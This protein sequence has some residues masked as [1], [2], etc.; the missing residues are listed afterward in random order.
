MENKKIDIDVM[1]GEIVRICIDNPNLLTACDL[2][3]SKIQE[4]EIQN[5]DKEY[6]KSDINWLLN[7][8]ESTSNRYM[9]AE[10]FIL[11]LPAI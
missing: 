6:S 5:K 9:E 7:K 10:S 1:C 8:V 3:K 11:E 4:Y 2:V